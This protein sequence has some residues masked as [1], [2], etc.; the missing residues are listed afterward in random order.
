MSESDDV[1]PGPSAGN[2]WP[3]EDGAIS[4]YLGVGRSVMRQSLHR[5]DHSWLRAFLEMFGIPAGDGG[6]VLACV[7][8]PG[9]AG[10]L[11]PALTPAAVARLGW[12]GMP[13]VGLDRDAGGAVAAVCLGGPGVSPAGLV[14]RVGSKISSRIRA[15]VWRG[16]TRL[17]RSSV[18]KLIGVP[19][20]RAPRP[21]WCSRLLWRTVTLPQRSIL[22]VRT[23]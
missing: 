6:A 23:R 3:H 10:G 4:V 16:M 12:I 7:R 8:G 1:E 11:R 9:P 13:A 17:C 2:G 22:S 20:R 14:V 15:P 18:S 21:M 5:D 19:A